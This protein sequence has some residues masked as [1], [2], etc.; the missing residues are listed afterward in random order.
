MEKIRVGLIGC[1]GRAG[2][3]MT[4]LLQMEDVQVV[5]VADPVEERRLAAAKRFGCSRI[6]KD[7]NELYANESKETVDALLIAVEPTAHVGIEEG[8]IEKTAFAVSVTDAEEYVSQAETD[9]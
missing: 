4:A 3:H 8:A 5:A 6:Y 9:E 7:H 2:N 1:G